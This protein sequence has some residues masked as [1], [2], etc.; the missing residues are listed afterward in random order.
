MTSRGA[1]PKPV[2]I[3]VGEDEAL[4]AAEVRG[5]LDDVVGGRDPSLAVEELSGDTGGEIDVGALIDAYTTPPFLIDRRVVV[6]R[7]AGRL[8]AAGAKRIVGVLDPPPPS[9][10]LILST[11]KGTIPAALRKMV[12]ALGELI[13]V[14]TKKAGDKKSYIQE[15]LRHGPVRINAA[16]QKALVDHLGD[17]LA[18]LSGLLETLASTY[19]TGVTVDELMLE[20]FLGTKGSVP[21]FDLTDAIDKGS[22]DLA[23][24]IVNRMMGPG[25]ISGHEILAS[26]DNHVSRLALLDG[27]DLTSGDEA[28]ALLGI[29]PYPAQKLLASARSLDSSAIRASVTLVADADLALKGTTGLSEQAVIEIL[30]ARLA[31]TTKTRVH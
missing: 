10:I 30:V 22:I 16:A 28:A 7:D 12:S 5:I 24:S 25:G 17:D 11:S 2:Y 8:D 6:V 27:A 9:A 18:R 13:D 14:S 21:I 15:H 29:H 20:P 1:D 31:R 26:L 3:V 19:G 23:V 4:V